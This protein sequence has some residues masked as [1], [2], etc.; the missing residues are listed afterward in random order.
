[1]DFLPPRNSCVACLFPT[2]SCLAF[3]ATTARLSAN[4]SFDFDTGLTAS[5]THTFNNE[6]KADILNN[7]GGVSVSAE[8][9]SVWGDNTSISHSALVLIKHTH[10]IWQSF[11]ADTFY[12]LL[13]LRPRFSTSTPTAKVTPSTSTAALFVQI[14][15]PHSQKPK[16][17]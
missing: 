5:T 15:L 14:T 3:L 11:N 4:F 8:G 7:G 6:N 10:N 2:L 9:I 13:L 16:G 17:V 1:M 12:G